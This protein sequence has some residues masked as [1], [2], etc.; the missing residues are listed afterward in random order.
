MQWIKNRV[1][2]ITL[3]TKM[4]FFAFRVALQPLL[5]WS[6]VPGIMLLTIK[7]P[8]LESSTGRVEETEVTVL[9]RHWQLAKW[10]SGALACDL[11][12]R[13]GE[14]PAYEDVRASCGDNIL[15]EWLTTPACETN[16]ADCAGLFLRYRGEATVTYLEEVQLPGIDAQIAPFNCAP[17]EWC[18]TRPLLEVKAMEPLAGYEINNIHIRIGGRNKVYRNADARFNL[19]LTDEQGSWLEYWVDSSYGD[20]TE[21][22]RI[23]YRSFVSDDGAAFHFD[24]LTSEWGDVLPSGTLLWKIFPPIDGLNPI[25]MQPESPIELYTEDSYLYLAGYLI[26]SGQA[27]ASD[28]SDG[29][30]Y[31]GGSASP[32]GEEAAEAQVIDWQNRYNAQILQA[33]RKYN[34]PAKLLKAII[35]Q[36]SQF[37]PESNDPYEKGLGYL[38]EDGL[39][40]LL[41]WNTEYYVE[42]CTSIF[43]EYLCSPGYA[44]LGETRQALLRKLIFDKIGTPEEIDVLAATL[45]ASATQSGKMVE[46][47]SGVEPI[48]ITTYVDLWKISTGNYYG[49]A[50][51]ISA[52]MTEIIE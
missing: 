19:P 5:I 40:M 17:G 11:Y 29:G 39:D 31:L 23:R 36:E 10:A 20:R 51:C 14:Y 4:K 3:F 45:L 44:E 1:L 50:G 7:S 52:P 35:A 49:G 15:V 22:I 24:L 21:P 38:T 30:L 32:C 48:Y 2:A 27:T 12:L 42:N 34:V 8:P 33:A 37:M 9:T 6:L 18:P 16:V 13:H 25:Y 41:M 26:Q 46:N 47:I 43:E 28:C